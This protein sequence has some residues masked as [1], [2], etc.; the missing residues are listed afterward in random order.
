VNP[1]KR[2]PQG[3]LPHQ[4]DHH[5]RDKNL[6]KQKLEQ[7]THNLKN[8]QNHVCIAKIKMLA[9]TMHFSNNTHPQPTPPPHPTTGCITDE[10]AL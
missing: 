7:N 3:T 2:N 6:Q 8:I 4:S 9:S 10:L 1:Q 5:Q